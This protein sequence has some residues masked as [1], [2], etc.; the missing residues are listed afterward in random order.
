[1]VYNAHLLARTLT[2]TIAQTCSEIMKIV[3]LNALRPQA[4]L[5]V[6]RRNQ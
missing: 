5:R 6:A 3:C 2:R 4:Q 1:M